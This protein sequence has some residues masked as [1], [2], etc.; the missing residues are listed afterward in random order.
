MSE[1]AAAPADPGALIRSK[2]YRVLLVFAALIGVLVSFASWCFL[3]LVHWIQQEVYKTLP[4]GLGLHPVPWWW[5]LPVLA[6]AGVLTAVAIMRL[7]GRGGHIPYEGIK[8]GTAKPAELPGILLAALATLGLGLVL[9]PEAPLIALGGGLAVLAVKLVKKDTPD[10]VMAVLAASAAFAAIATIFGSPVIGAIILIEAAGLGGPMLPLMLLPGLMSAGIGSVIFIGMGHW[11]GLSSSAYALSPFSLPAFSTLTAAEF[12]WAIVLAFAAA[13]ATVAIIEG[14]RRSAHIVARQPWLLLPAAALAVGGLAIGFAQITHQPADLVLFSG[15]DA[16][17]SLI[18]QGPTLALSTLAFL[19]LFKGLAWSISLGSFRGGPTFPALFIGAAGGLLAAHLPGFSETPAVAVLM[20]AAVV[21]I[22]RLPLSAT[23]ITLLLVSKAGIATAPLIIVAVVVAYLTIQT[24]SPARGPATPAAPASAAGP[25]PAAPPRT[26]PQPQTQATVR[27][28]HRAPPPRR[29]SCERG[30][31]MAIGPVQLIVLG[32]SHPDFHGEIIAELER[33]HA[34]GTVRV[35]DSLAVYKDADGELEVEHLSN[36]SEAEA[37]ELGS[38][39]GALIGL[40]IDG[41]EGME[42]GAIAGAEQAA[43]EGV[44]VF[45]E[46]EG[47]DVL[48]DI[49]NDSAAA[50]ILLEH[51]WAVP[52]RDAIVRAGGF[53]LSDGFISPLDL[54]EIGLLSAEEA[55]ELHDLETSAAASKP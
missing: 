12:G 17:S 48:E 11:T 41:E 6:I 7:P 18:K 15:Q 19:L 4:S 34:S 23:V 22:L 14:A 26:P 1:T 39:I 16:F 31:K 24:L 40:G 21:S 33:L 5:P 43:A 3:E 54:V 13:V 42:A 30:K 38:K 53:R 20:A 32:F 8:A 55:Q 52:L 35:I 46:E 47:W 28:D 10:Q 9:G 44:H 50:L 36:L 45:T 49:P 51:H 37:I 27:H 29:R 25:Q 2:S